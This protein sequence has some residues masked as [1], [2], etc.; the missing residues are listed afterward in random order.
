MPLVGV[1]YFRLRLKGDLSRKL[2]IDLGA[3]RLVTTSDGVVIENPKSFDKVERRIKIL[4]RS[5]SRKRGSRNH[6]KARRKLAKL[7][8]H[9]KNLMSDYIHKVTSWFVEHYDEVYVEDLEVKEM[10]EGTESETLRKHIL[11]AT[12]PARLK[13]LVGGW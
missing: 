4:Q 12:S 7:H 6:E 8:E 5:L 1:R 10:V 9:V 2:E 11:R 3:D 13:E